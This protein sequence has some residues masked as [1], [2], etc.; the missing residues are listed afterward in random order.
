M[1]S[2]ERHEA[3]YRRRVAKRAEKKV[4]KLATCN[5]FEKVF[6]YENLYK[7]YRKSRCNVAWKASMQKYI[8]QA[9]ANIQ[10]TLEKLLEGTFK[11]YGFVE[12]DICERGKLR[13]IKSVCIEERIVQRCLCDYSLVPALSRTFIHDN[14]A[15]LKNKGYTF[16]VRRIT[17]HLREHYRK[18]GTDG[19]ILTFDFSKFFDSISHE[20]IKKI[21]RRE[22]TN[23]KL[24]NLIDHFIDAF[25]GSA[26][27]GL[28]SQVS[29]IFALAAANRLDHFVKEILG[30]KHY[31]RYMDDG[32]LIH[33][34]KEYLASCL[35]SIRLICEELDL[36][37]N[38]KK[39]QIVKLSHGFSF[40][41]VHFRITESGKIIKTMPHGSITK[42]RHKLKSFYVLYKN[43]K[44]TLQDVYASYQSWRAYSENFNAYRTRR[45]MDDLYNNLFIFTKGEYV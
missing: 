35:S 7:S 19:Y 13:H 12:F 30:V 37:L 22:L 2:Q 27:I 38:E 41:K 9:P 16:S 25:G 18:Y 36:K 33:P 24:L 3:R 17:Q 42:M 8:C 40:L 43:G 1:T 10:I 11:S 5:D 34:S 29:Q 31:G 39:T 26:G 28:G 20:L 32:Y 23:T 6:S 21:V 14:G 44:M 45:N 15:S 4:K